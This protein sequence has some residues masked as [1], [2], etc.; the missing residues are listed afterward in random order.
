MFSLT[1][2]IFTPRRLNHELWIERAN[3]MR[4]IRADVISCEL[5]CIY[6]PLMSQPCN[7]VFTT[8]LSLGMSL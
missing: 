2:R 5:L 6:H 3:A 8:P 4:R 1:W 7:N